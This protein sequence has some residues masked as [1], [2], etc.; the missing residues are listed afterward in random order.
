MEN[1]NIVDVPKPPITHIPLI[2]LITLLAL[3]LFLSAFLGYQN[4]K[5]QKQIIKL[6]VQPSPTPIKGEPQKCLTTTDPC[7]PL[8]CDYN[9]QKCQ[10]SKIFCGGIA[11][12]ACPSGFACQ[13]DGNYPDA[14][15]T[16]VR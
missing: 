4:Q 11:G 3:S 12:V 1:L 10:S 14:S 13:Y 15:G 8:G 6:S 5:L 2:T 9:L 7:E 16:C